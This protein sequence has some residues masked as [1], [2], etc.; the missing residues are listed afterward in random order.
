[1]NIDI[2][3]FRRSL[4]I[5]PSIKQEWTVKIPNT[6]QYFRVAT[7]LD[8]IIINLAKP[9]VL[10]KSRTKKRKMALP[11]GILPIPPRKGK[12]CPKCHGSGRIP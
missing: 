9:K 8:N 12:V 11:E 7:H 3:V 4:S 1:M 10:E 5:D 2:K 6:D